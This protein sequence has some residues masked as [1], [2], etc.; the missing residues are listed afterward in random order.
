VNGPARQKSIELYGG[1]YEHTLTLG[2]DAASLTIDYNVLP[3]MEM[4][5]RMITRRAFEA[6]EFSLAN[7]ILLKDGGADWL[8]AIPVFPNRSFRHNT[9]FVH[10]Q[11]PLK[12]PAELRGRRIG[13]EDYS[14][15][16]AVWVRGFLQEQYG[17]HWS[18]LDWYCNVAHQRF[19]IPDGA[20]V[21]AVSADLEDMLV[22]GELDALI[23]FGPRDERL[24]RAQ[25]KLRRLIDDVENV[26]KVYFRST[27]IYPINHCVVVRSD[28]LERMPEV[29]ALLFDAYAMSKA[30]AYRRRLGA[31]LVPWAKSNWTDVFE[32]FGGDPLPYGLT[33]QNLTVVE[34]LIGH[35]YEQKFIAKRWTPESLFVEGSA[36]LRETRRTAAGTSA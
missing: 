19:P 16:A 13:V 12:A 20:K 11:S 15:T 32:F 29:P 30:R 6:C 4:F 5:S 21:T 14:M 36:A 23:S 25:R 8:H 35:L 9:L 24:P 27:G 10:A 34:R 1:D 3:T 7:Y 31:T 26:E 2:G 18:E 28:L 17:V 22:S 33:D